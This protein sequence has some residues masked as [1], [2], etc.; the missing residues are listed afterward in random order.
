MRRRNF[1][2]AM[3]AAPGAA[4][5]TS[6]PPASSQRNAAEPS[7]FFFDDGRHAAGLYQF[8]PPLTAADHV[9]TVDQLIHSGVDTY[10]YGATLE[11]GVV[12]YDSRVAQKWGDNVKKWKHVVWYRASRVLNQLI[13]DGHDPLKLLIDRCHQNGIWF[14]ASCYVN[15]AG[16][17]RATHG[18]LGRKS[19]FVY[20]HPEFQVGPDSDPRARDLPPDRFNFLH[21]ELQRERFTVAEELLTRFETDGIELN[22]ADPDLAFP[23]CRFSEAGKLAPVL[24]EWIRRVK[25]AARAAEQAQGRRKRIYA[26]IPA[27]PGTWPI[28]GYEVPRWVNEG[29]VDGLICVSNDVETMDQ[30]L[31][32]EAVVRLTRGH[33]CR[34][35]ASFC[36]TLMRQ[37][38]KY[39]TP[40]M[41]WAAAASA[42]AQ[43]ADGVGLGDAHWTPN[44]WPW[45]SDEYSTLRLLGHPELLATADKHYHVR[46]AQ[47]GAPRRSWL[48]GAQRRLPRRLS[49]G[50]TLEV[51]LRVADDLA[52][53]H[54]EQ[55]LKSV[56]LQ[57]RLTNFQPSGDRI[58]V[59]LNGVPLPESSAEKN[60][61]TY[62]LLDFGAASPYGY[63]FDYRLA[64][65]HFPANG[66]NTIRVTLVESD[67]TLDLPR[68]VHDVDCLVEYRP[69]RN[70]QR[71]PIQ[72]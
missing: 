6:K 69:H 57:V 14:L 52:S 67:T 4:A 10:V 66:H 32:L 31:D 15:L 68:E 7:V 63:V 38:Q 26:R 20:D 33:S 58:R 44:G 45:T 39:A 62:R 16:G 71:P 29:L 2:T 56:R 55:K 35:L 42:Y 9:F 50:E 28:A 54:R 46:S 30:D 41:I 13:A 19:D 40:P 23:F 27:H 60:D 65:E 70:F 64:P 12:Q 11:G 5:Q 34:V 59:E 43:G 53:F 22:L 61:L 72:Y 8:E 21:P 3:G 48:P 18:G 24:T 47:Q 1:L 37:I 36:N 25:A 17:D 49:A 51:P